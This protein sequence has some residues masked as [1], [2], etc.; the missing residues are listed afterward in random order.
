VQ[1]TQRQ[2]RRIVFLDVD[3]TLLD[4]DQHLAPTAAEAVRA[5]RGSGHLVYL[6]TGRSRAEIPDQVTDVG[7]DGVISAGGGFVEHGDTL[8]ASHAMPPAALQEITEFFESHEIEYLLQSYDAVYPSRG[9]FP[10]VRPYFEGNVRTAPERAAADLRRL[11]QRMTY[12]GPAPADGIAKST[13]FGLHQHTF[14]LVQENLG[15]RFHVL[16]GTI[17]YLGEAGG[18][19]SLPGM[20]KGAA[21]VE[22][23]A[24]LGLPLEDAIGIGDSTND[25]EMFDICGVGIAM[26]NASDAVKARA[27]EVTTSV[28]DDGIRNAFLTHR[29]I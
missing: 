7:F 5:A 20:N 19:I 2:Q 10:R 23:V 16:T 15:E 9:L 3:G 4:H 22:L 29:L 24:H 27:D 17:P 13:F 8:V 18:E 1:Q 26:G 6:C 11:E 28:H 21:I 12:R 25:L 14:R